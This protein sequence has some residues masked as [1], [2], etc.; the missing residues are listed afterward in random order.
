MVLAADEAAARA[1]W[2]AIDDADGGVNLLRYSLALETSPM[3]S[4]LRPAGPN[5]A[6]KCRTTGA[7]KKIIQGKFYFEENTVYERQI[8]WENPKLYCIDKSFNPCV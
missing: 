5:L 1:D 3:T 4:G 2:L 8:M 6:A 7:F